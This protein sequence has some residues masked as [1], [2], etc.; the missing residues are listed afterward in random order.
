PAKRALEESVTAAL[1]MEPGLDVS[2]VPSLYDMEPG[3]TGR[4][5]LEGVRGDVV[6]LTWM[7][8]RAAFWLLDRSGIKGHYGENQIAAKPDEDEGEPEP[9]KGIGAV[10]VPN[11]HIYTLD[12]RDHTD[13]R[14]YVDE[15]KRIAAECAE[16]RQSQVKP[17]LVQLG[18]AIK[19]EA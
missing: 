5:F 11:R 4:M 16:R 19:T 12:L 3:H 18:L 15:I 6:V 7:F 13:H 8:S 9:P 1:I 14:V 17:A 10:D 2:I